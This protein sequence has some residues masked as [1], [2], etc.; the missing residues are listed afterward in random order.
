VEPVDIDTPRGTPEV[1]A[2]LAVDTMDLELWLDLR[3]SPVENDSA[4]AILALGRLSN[5]T[6]VGFAKLG[7]DPVDPGVELL[8]F[9]RR[10][11]RDVLVETLFETE[12][13]H[14]QVSW[15]LPPR[16]EQDDPRRWARSVGE[17]FL[18][19]LRNA[20]PAGGTDAEV[21][22]AIQTRYFVDGENRVMR[23]GET[24]LW[25]PAEPADL[26]PGPHVYS[27]P[28]QGPSTLIDAGEW[29]LLAHQSG[30]QA[31]QLMQEYGQELDEALY[32]EI[33]ENLTR[34]AAAFD[35]AHKFL[36][37]GGDAIP[38]AACWSALGL[39]VYRE[40]AALFQ[41]SS[42][43]EQRGKY[44]EALEYVRSTFGPVFEPGRG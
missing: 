4:A 15:Q 1:I 3:F 34:A 25:V 18:Y 11:P 7:Y 38:V 27:A 30:Q 16:A 23:L 42:L 12:L 36:P 41:R 22:D 21:L 14:D 2:K 35:E 9:G 6:L 24:E 10:E 5:G 37:A 13:K 43:E 33:D 28:S 32:F 20:G 31:V 17:A 39:Q 44:R 40:G 26:P 19:F 8:Q 29:V